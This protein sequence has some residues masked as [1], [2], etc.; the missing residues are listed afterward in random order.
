M[1]KRWMSV[2]LWSAAAIAVVA[3]GTAAVGAASGPGSNVLSANDVKRE[4][5]AASP[6]P[7]MSR[8]TNPVPSAVGS[9]QMI[10]TN[11]G[12]VVAACSQG[13]VEVLRWSPLSEYRTDEVSPTSGPTATVK[14]ESDTKDDVTVVLHCEN[15]VVKYQAQVQPDDHGGQRT[16]PPTP[17][18][19]DNH[20][21]G[22]GGGGTDDPPGDNHGG[23]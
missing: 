19:S 12:A 10:N 21:G 16:A 7:S 1:R 20:G 15:G 23:R 17:G 14:F 3:V 22:G 6:E 9:S 4:L 5:S 8:S 18:A 2:M 13:Q 11:A